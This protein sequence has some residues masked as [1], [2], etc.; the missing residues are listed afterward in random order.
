MRSRLPRKYIDRD[1][2]EGQLERFFNDYVSNNAIYID[3]Q[4]QQR[5][6]MCRD[7]FL[8]IVQALGNQ[9]S[10]FQQQVDATG[11]MGLS[12]L[13]KCTVVIRILA[14]GSPVD[15]IDDYVQMGET[16]T[17]LCFDKFVRGV[18]DVFEAKYLR[19]PNNNDIQYLLQ[20][21]EH[22]G[23]PSMLGSID[24][25]F[26]VNE[27]QY[28]MGF[29]LADGIYRNWTT[30]VKTIQRPQ[31]TIKHIL[32]VC[33]ILHSMIIEE[34]HTYNENFD[35]QY[36][37]P[38]NHVVTTHIILVIKSYLLRKREVY[39]RICHHQLQTDLVEYI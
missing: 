28:N 10:Y 35:H 9:D 4:F 26:V 25:K 21:S 39:D 36:K 32:Y 8:R 30:L 27:I 3:E 16:M 12:P 22:Y 29:F 24:L 34:R 6:R 15:S 5:F 13:Q 31:D 2:E 7:V 14:Y 18:Y 20:I 37:Y 23:F 38:T 1:R 19:R 17:L 33:I 11:R